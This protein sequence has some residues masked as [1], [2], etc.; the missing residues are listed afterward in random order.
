MLT[1]VELSKLQEKGMI[2]IP[3]I[4]SILSR[5][6]EEGLKWIFQ[7]EGENFFPDEEANLNEG[8]HDNWVYTN[9]V[10]ASIKEV[11]AVDMLHIIFDKGGHILWVSCN[12]NG[13]DALSDW[14]THEHID[15]W[16]DPIS[17]NYKD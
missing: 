11:D 4:V 17:Q 8:D 2:K 15:S 3:L 6:K 7:C 5:A 12:G 10:E 9:D 16:L 14:T 13:L 1:Q